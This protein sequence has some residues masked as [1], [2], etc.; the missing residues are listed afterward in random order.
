MEC[1]LGN[2]AHHD[3]VQGQEHNFQEPSSRLQKSAQ[4]YRRS[5]YF[6][7]DEIERSQPHPQR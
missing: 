6:L 1:K 5:H 2:K 3:S 4:I 7:T